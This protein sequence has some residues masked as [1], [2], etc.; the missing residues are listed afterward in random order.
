MV[1]CSSYRVACLMRLLTTLSAVDNVLERFVAFNDDRRLIE[2]EKILRAATE[3]SRVHKAL[4]KYTIDARLGGNIND[5]PRLL[6]KAMKRVKESRIVFT[7]CSGAGLGILRN[8]R[9]DTVLIDEASQITEPCALIPL[10]KGCHRAVLVGDH[11]QLRPTVKPMG[12]ALEFDKSLFERLW[13]GLD[14]PEL[15]RTMLERT[16]LAFHLKNSTRV[17]FE[18]AL[19]GMPRSPLLSVSHLSR[20]PPLRN[21]SVQ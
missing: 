10:V 14:Y 15:A 5:N 4:Q 1:G 8:A 18:R 12:K 17:D 21:G 20:G 19:Q 3:S 16:S 11:V 2:D 13:R 7:T 9:F 6:Q